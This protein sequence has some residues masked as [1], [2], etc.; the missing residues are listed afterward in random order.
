MAGP[1]TSRAPDRA[2]AAPIIASGYAALPKSGGATS[3]T[4][5]QN[6]FTVPG[7]NCASTPNGTA[8]MRAG[9]GGVSGGSTIQRVGI[10]ET[11]KGGAASY[12]SWYQMYPAPPVIEFSPKP[13]DTL[14]YSVTFAK[15]VYTLSIQDPTSGESFSV[16]KLCAATCSNNSAQVT[17]GPAAGVSPANFIAVN[18]AVIIVT[19]NAGVSGGLANPDWNTGTLSQGGSPRTV[20]GPLL[21]TSGPPAQ[22]AFQ[23]TW[24]T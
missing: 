17:A 2:A 24:T 18:F 6:T 11:C 8:E 15:G 23:D 5:V 21:T 13:G 19:D 22:S 10:S 4:H 3:F 7:L 20:A 14:N 12:S 9:I 16:N 1:V